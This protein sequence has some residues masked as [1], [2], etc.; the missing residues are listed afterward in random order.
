MSDVVRELVGICRLFGSFERE[1]V[2]CG[3][4]TVQQCVVLQDLLEGPSDVSGLAERSFVSLSA[5]TRLLDGLVQRDWAER[6]RGEEDRRRVQVKLTSA[7]TKE[8]TRLRD[9]TAQCVELVLARVPKKQRAQAKK[10]LSLVHA[11]LLQARADLT[12]CC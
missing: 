8:A 7:G 11:A 12:S 9:A 6:R 5:M 4:V 2:C 10:S 1:A 3:S